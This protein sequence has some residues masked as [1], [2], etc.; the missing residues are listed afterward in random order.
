MVE[1]A[2]QSSLT[3]PSRSENGV[4]RP[5][6]SKL[7]KTRIVKIHPTMIS[8]PMGVEFADVGPIEIDLARIPLKTLNLVQREVAAELQEREQ[9]TY[10][11]NKELRKMARQLRLEAHTLSAQVE[12]CQ[13]EEVKQEQA[14]VT[15]C[16][17]LPNCP[18]DQ[19]ASLAQKFKIV[20][21]RTKELERYIE[22]MDT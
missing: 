22:K 11:A 13:K 12:Q 15:I 7:G 19:S 14:I 2:T 9:A 10:Q 5:E 21:S 1:K 4:L 16:A 6:T 20:A 8:L 3:T 18:I 17:E